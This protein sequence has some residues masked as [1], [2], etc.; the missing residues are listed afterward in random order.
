MSRFAWKHPTLTVII[1]AGVTLGIIVGAGNAID[2]ID[3]LF[4]MG[5]L[6]IAMLAG[7]ACLGVLKP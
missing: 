4:V 1:A 7:M 3:P 6:L 5:A 2:R